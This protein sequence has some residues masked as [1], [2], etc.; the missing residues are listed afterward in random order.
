MNK[1]VT[2]EEIFDA[3]VEKT[4]NK[5][6]FTNDYIHEFISV[7]KEGLEKDGKVNVSGL[8]I[9]KLN[10]IG[11]QNRINPQTGEDIKIPAHNKIHFKPEKK[12]KAFVNRE[13]N[14]LK[15]EEIVT[16]EEKQNKEDIIEDE[17]NV[18]GDGDNGMS[19]TSKK[20]TEE[21]I[22][23]DETN[24]NGD[25]D[26]GMSTTSK[27]ST[28]EDIIKDETNVNS[29]D[30]NGMST[31][32]KISTEEDIIKNETNVYGDEDNDIPTISNESTEDIITE[33]SSK[34]FPYIPV[35]GTLI[36][37]II[38][39][40]LFLFFNKKDNKPYSSI[41]PKLE[42]V[43]NKD[44]A[45]IKK[46][47]IAIVKNKKEKTDIIKDKKEKIDMIKDKKQSS[48]KKQKTMHKE[49]SIIHQV[50]SGNTLWE[51]ANKYY[52]N[53]PLWPNIYRKNIETVFN[54]DIIK[55]GMSIEVPNLEGTG[56]NLTKQDSFNIAEG[57]YLSYLSYKKIGKKK[58]SEFLRIAKRFNTTVEK[59]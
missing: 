38:L 3:I 17:T 30:D 10:W 12:M 23:K 27:K 46:G 44:T 51:L 50:I 6:V 49:T 32:S 15:P 48:V 8:G 36:I 28:E 21:D 41:P 56:Y 59:K 29:D 31:T 24:V 45:K 52:D 1:K 13:Y 16:K 5:K 34:K 9:F 37:I 26:N 22:I 54:P 55:S 7:V 33:E 57:Y 42:I 35:F 47:K 2:S 14:H 53:A 11:A 40:L 18:N 4:G 39:F 25:D 19:T 43:K 20:S 58:A